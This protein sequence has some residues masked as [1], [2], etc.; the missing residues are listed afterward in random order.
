MSSRVMVQ[1]CRSVPISSSLQRFHCLLVALRI[2]SRV[3]NKVIE[4]GFVVG[5]QF[6]AVGLDL[7][8][9]QFDYI[10]DSHHCCSYAL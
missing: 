3:L 8:T 9:F 4:S 7:A 5:H 1:K 10:S 6:M 2:N